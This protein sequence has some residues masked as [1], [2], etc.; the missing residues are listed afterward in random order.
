MQVLPENGGKMKKIIFVMGFV[1]LSA[2]IFAIAPEDKKFDLGVS[3][4]MLGSGNFE[5]SWYDDFDPIYTV[6]ETNVPAFLGRAVFDYYIMPFFAIGASL[7]YAAIVTKNDINWVDD[8]YHSVS[9]NDIFILDYCVGIKYRHVFDGGF[10]IKPGVALGGRN[11]FS[12]SYEAREFGMA[13]DVSV[14]AQY[15]LKEFGYVYVDCGLLSQPY[16]GVEDIAYVRGGPIY[17]I[18]VGFGI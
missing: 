14:E 17:Y 7:A 2:G 13:L 8:G 18:T 15:Y 10:V 6:K 9:K 4:G 16:G 11:S 12:H 1:F 3:F 5:A